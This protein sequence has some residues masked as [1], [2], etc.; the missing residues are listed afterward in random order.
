MKNKFLLEE[1]EERIAPA[2]LTPGN[3]ISW[4]DANGDEVT[5]TYG[6][7]PDGSQV[8]VLD[9]F[10]GD[11]GAGDDIGTITFTGANLMSELVVTCN[12]A[13]GND[14]VITGGISAPGGQDVGTI[15]VGLGEYST[16]MGDAV[17]GSGF[18]IDVGGRLGVLA[19]N[20]DI[21][22]DTMNH[23]VSTGGDIGLIYIGGN[24][25][26]EPIGPDGLAHFS[27]GA[28]GDADIGFIVGQD[29]YMGSGTGTP[30]SPTPF[31]TGFT[32]DDDAGVG[33]TGDLRVTVAAAAPAGEYTAIP[34]TG[35]G[36][37]L[38]HVE[39]ASP[40][41]VVTVAGI[42]TGGDVTG[43]AF[44]ANA[45][46]LYITGA[47]DTDV[48]SVYGDAAIGTVINRTPG[49]D[50]GFLTVNGSVGLIQTGR[51]GNLGTIYTAPG[52][53]MP[54]FEL[55]EYTPDG[56]TVVNG[57]IGRIQVGAISDADIFADSIGVITARPGSIQDVY[58]GVPGG[59]GLISTGGIGESEI[60]VGG[61][62]GKVIVGP[63]P[64]YE[65]SIRAIGGIGSFTVKGPVIDTL[66]SAHEDVMGTQIGAGIGIFSADAVFDS[67]IEAL[68]GIGKV[69]VKGAFADS[70]IDTKFTDTFLGDVGGP[71]GSAS[72]GG[73]YDAS[74]QSWGSIG[75]LRVGAGGIR[76]GSLIETY[77]NLNTLLVAG[78]VDDT[79]LN[80]DYGTL[81][82]FRVAGNITHS[83][84]AIYADVMNSV[85]VSGSYIAATMEAYSSAGVISIRGGLHGDQPSIVVGGNLGLFSVNGGVSSNDSLVLDVNGTAASVNV[86]GGMSFSRME[87]DNVGRLSLGGVTYNSAV[88]IC[89]NVGLFTSGPLVDT[90]LNVGGTLGAGRVNGAFID[91]YA[92]I[93]GSSGLLSV[94]GDVIDGWIEVRGAAFAGLQVKGDVVHSEID[95]GDWGVSATATGVLSL[96]GAVIDAE[97]DTYGTLSMLSARG[98]VYGLDHEGSDDIG[99]VVFGRSVVDSNVN[100]DGSLGVVSVGGSMFSSDLSAD[101]GIAAVQVRGNL[102]STEIDA[103]DYDGG[104]NPLPVNIGIVSAKAMLDSSVE[105]TGNLS[106]VLVRGSIDGCWIS[107]VGYDNY[108]GGSPVSGG[109]I[110][111]LRANGLLWSGV[112]TYGDMGPVRLGSL[113]MAGSIET[114]TGDFAGL[115]TTGLVYGEMTIAGDL[116]GNIL[117]AGNDAIF[118]DDVYYFTDQNGGIVGGM[119]EVAGT[120]APGV[121]I[122]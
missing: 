89:G 47:V 103:E 63:G 10:G 1:L 13:G 48:L 113:G 76:Y 30:V 79:H 98:Q 26:L 96:G 53:S 19:L 95:T 52:N 119:L 61:A 46:A 107:T 43:I 17:L 91:S 34:V 111:T 80:V 100:T 114:F 97:I 65:S 62:I 11:V 57:S 59:I 86:R 22:F 24:L 110:G 121:I 2:V 69:T 104:G 3:G 40:N 50:I 94:R 85:Q 15:N 12:G 115:T 92:G 93:G 64:V 5:V 20:G 122:S 16:N 44:G 70:E 58:I 27:A 102:V 101:A 51:L 9:P 81:G 120:V 37:V 31:T 112:E 116:T 67:R 39:I 68:T 28:G 83:N 7:G 74:V 32:I 49:G 45:N 118:Y 84:T 8:E 14:I 72:F 21:D 29:V 109:S 42:G 18:S 6:E 36:F 82:V 41:A 75:L 66:V 78:D 87:I 33:G 73:L 88:G 38:S 105:A 90:S 106:A 25:H 56:G 35:G 71:V 54:L 23:S 55:F 108:G 99:R 117:S 4:T 60:D 77:G